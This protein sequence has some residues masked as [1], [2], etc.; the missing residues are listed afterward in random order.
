VTLQLYLFVVAAHAR[1][2][3][4]TTA[5]VDYF[6]F[7]F[8]TLSTN[9][10]I[11]LVLTISLQAKPSKPSTFARRR[12]VQLAIAGLHRHGRNRRFAG[13]TQCGAARGWQKIAEVMHHHALP[14]L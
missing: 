8:F 2:T 11:A 13:A 5:V 7:G 4:V 9:F 10:L 1:G 14:P 6:Y 3:S 12:K